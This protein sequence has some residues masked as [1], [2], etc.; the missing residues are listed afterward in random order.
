MWSNMSV[1]ILYIKS[2]V[3]CKT[4]FLMLT[5]LARLLCTRGCSVVRQFVFYCSKVNK[6]SYSVSVGLGA[7]LKPSKSW[8]VVLGSFWSLV[9]VFIILCSLH[10]FFSC[11][12]IKLLILFYSP[13]NVCNVPIN[14]LLHILREWFTIYLES[15]FFVSGTKCCLVSNSYDRP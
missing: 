11:I 8:T 7:L 2:H 1:F 6:L 13:I 9:F 10:I 3:N 14:V 15:F 4:A 12:L 5:L